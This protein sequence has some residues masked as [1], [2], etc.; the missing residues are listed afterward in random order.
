MESLTV[1]R[2]QIEN[3]DELK[4]TYPK[5]EIHILTPWSED[6]NEMDNQSDNESNN[7]SDN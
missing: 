3:L 2:N 1:H 4:K 7:Q 6:N 5:I